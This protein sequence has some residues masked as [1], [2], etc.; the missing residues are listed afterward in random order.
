MRD[1]VFTIYRSAQDTHGTPTTR[2]WD[3]WVE[4]LTTHPLRGD[5]TDANDKPA[6]DRAKNGP[7]IILGEIPAGKP[8]RGAN[9]R[10]VHALGL[11]LEG[12]D[13][14][15]LK[16]IL[17]RLL[18]FE[19]V[20][21][22]THKSGAPAV[23]G[24]TRLRIV[25]PLR[26]PLTP[27]DH[28]SAWSGLN[29]LIGGH[30]LKNESYLIGA[31]VRFAIRTLALDRIERTVNRRGLHA[32]SIRRL[33]QSLLRMESDIDLRKVMVV[34]RAILLDTMEWIRASRG[35]AAVIGGSTT[36]ISS[37]WPYLP[38]IP[39]LDMVGGVELMTD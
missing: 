4:R 16:D 5:T 2:T 13:D 11:D 18:P 33:E 30:N 31:L 12:I 8:R 22:T 15:D 1:V 14:R 38:V 25:L 27:S 21:Y 9:M 7:A 3:E 29:A 17:N 36:D 32:E 10:A 26:E 20:V 35:G 34:E 28:A 6:L 23:G 19:F 37:I 24:E 39:A